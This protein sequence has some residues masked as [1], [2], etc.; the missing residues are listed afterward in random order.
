M[1]AAAEHMEGA[2][3]RRRRRQLG[4]EEEEAAGSGG[5]SGAGRGSR[6]GGKTG[7]RCQIDERS[8]SSPSQLL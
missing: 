4:Q 3:R 8:G 7:V 2:G 5:G 6:A 1:I